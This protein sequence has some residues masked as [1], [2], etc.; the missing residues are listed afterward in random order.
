[1]VSAA[2]LAEMQLLQHLGPLH[3]G[4]GILTA[5]LALV[6][7]LLL[8]VVVGVMTRRDRARDAGDSSVERRS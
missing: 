7:F 5:L 2:V 4:E 8:A 3:A 1:M 6:P